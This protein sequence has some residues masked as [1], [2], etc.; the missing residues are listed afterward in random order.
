MSVRVAPSPPDPRLVRQGCSP[1]SVLACAALIAALAPGAAV[2]AQSSA[3][4]DPVTG[5]WVGRIGPGTNPSNQVTMHLRA[6]GAEVGG[7]LT[8]LDQPGDVRHGHYDATTG[9]LR[10]ELGIT[11]QEGVLMI[12]EGTAVQGTA[13]GRV[14]RGNQSGTF[15]L[16]RANGSPAGGADATSATLPRDQLRGAFEEVS[17][18]IARA[19]ELV[20]ADR[21]AYQPVGTVRTLG[22]LVGHIVDGYHFYCGR[23]AGR[24]GQWSDSTAQG[25]LDKAT[26]AARLRDATAQ[27]VAAYASGNVGPLI[28]NTFHAN[29]HYGNLVTYL[30]LLGL[31]PSSS[32]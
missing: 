21:Y 12:L 27:C 26:L 32:G 1:R 10:L 7:T 14:T 6:A 18:H 31:V 17:G 5:T 30:R 29:L 22:Q 8:G 11:G 25:T 2:S 16:T 23:A 24:N 28:V 9:A 3:S 20:P 19:A 15:V 13:V 4:A